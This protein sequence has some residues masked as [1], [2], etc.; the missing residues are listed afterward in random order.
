MSDEAFFLRDFP[1]RCEKLSGSLV[2]SM[3]VKG[4]QR[5]V[6]HG[7]RSDQTA[8]EAILLVKPATM[9]VAADLFCLHFL[10]FMG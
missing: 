2:D 3:P 1:Q 9:R 4:P 5:T 10:S 6:K 7:E 8:P